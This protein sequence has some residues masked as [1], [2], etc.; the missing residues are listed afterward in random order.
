MLRSNSQKNSISFV[1]FK[2]FFIILLNNMRNTLQKPSKKKRVGQKLKPEWS[3]MLK[4]I[5]HV[6]IEPKPY[7]CDLCD[8][9][10]Q[11]PMN[12]G[13]H[14]AHDHKFHDTGSMD[15][16]KPSARDGYV[17]PKMLQN[18]ALSMRDEAAPVMSTKV[19]R[20]L[21]FA[22]ESKLCTRVNG[23]I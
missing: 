1:V 8:K 2:I 11:R 13:R 12:L 10:F 16:S 14:V 20:Q 5:H 21:T 22:D 18:Y 4:K 3:F 6:N 19:Q 9:R 15:V 17:L 7:K 23:K